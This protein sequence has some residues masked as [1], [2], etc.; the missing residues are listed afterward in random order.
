MSL[1]IRELGGADYARWDAFVERCPA[2]TFFHR[3]GWS[4]VI[5][6]AFGQST[7]YL[8]AESD[9]R[10]R[11]VL[12]LAHRRSLLFGNALIS[13]PFCVY[14]GV[15]AEDDAVQLVLLEEGS[16]LARRLNVDYLEVR[17]LRAAPVDW[18]VKSLYVTFRKQIESSDEANLRAIPRKQRA[19]V[20]KGIDARLRATIDRLPDRLYEAY[21]CSVRNLGTP[22]FARRY[23]EVLQQVFGEACEI[24][25]VTDPEDRLIGSVMSFYFRDEVLPYYGGGMTAARA[26]KGNDF[27]YWQVMCRARERGA[28]IFDYGRS[29]RGSGSFSFKTHWGFTPEPLS[30]QYY[31]VRAQR[32]PD[33]SPS[34][35]KFRFFIETWKRLP[36]GVTRAFGPMLARHLG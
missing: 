29:R 17:C 22:V 10:I 13:T 21:S 34:N 24:L 25:T 18:P 19:M 1:Q 4:T 15:A 23:F 6:E 8:Y 14:G 5:E 20:R 32:P 3:A 11:G 28:R 30:Y 27:M 35:S 12:P 26:V 7:H 36:V 16:R 31:L 9:G 2:A 33:L